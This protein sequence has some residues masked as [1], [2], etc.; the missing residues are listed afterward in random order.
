MSL[1]S[2][3]L[4]N[5]KSLPW[6]KKA[7]YQYTIIGIAFG[8]LFPLFAWFLDAYML[9]IEFF[10]LDSIVRVHSI[11]YT[12]YIIDVAPL[13]LGIMAYII[14]KKQEISVY[15]ANNELALILDS[16]QEGIYGVDLKGRATFANPASL[17]LIGY[18]LEEV[19]GK[20][21]HNLMHH[22]KADG[23]PYPK[24]ECNIYKAFSE[25]KAYNITDEVFWR[26]DGISFPVEYTSNPIYNKKGAVTGAVVVFRDITERK[27]AEDSLRNQ[28]EYL[29]IMLANIVEGII[30]INEDGVIESFNK[31]A[32]KIFEYDAKEVIG[33]NVKMLMPQPYKKNHDSYLQNYVNTGEEKI[34]GT[35]GREVTGLRKGGSEFP[36]ELGVNLVQ[37]D[38]KRHF[39]GIVRDISEKIKFEE[40]ELKRTRELEFVNFELSMAKSEADEA[41]RAKSEFLANMSH[42]IRTPMNG[43]MGMSELLLNTNLTS[44]QSSYTKTVIRSS[45]ALLELIDD[46]L[47]FSKI[48]SGRMELESVVFDLQLLMEDVVDLLSIKTREKGVELIL[49]YKAETPRYVTGDPVRVR[50]IIYNLAG[51]AIKFTAEGHVLIEVGVIAFEYDKVEI[52]IAVEDTGLG[53]PKDKQELIFEKFSQTDM[54][55]TRKYGGTG[56]GLAISKQLA[57]MMEGDINVKSEEGKGSTFEVTMRL[58]VS[59]KESDSLIMPKADIEGVKVLVVD[60]NEVARGVI[61]E[62][63]LNLGVNVESAA[64]GEDALSKLRNAHKSGQDFSI[65]TIDDIMEDIDGYDLGRA[66]KADSDIKDISLIMV[67]STPKRGDGKEA[68]KIGF[69]GYLTKPLHS[70]ELEEAISALWGAKKENVDKIFI[71]R[72]TLLESDELLNDESCKKISFK[73]V[74]ILLVDDN[75]V[76]QMVASKMLETFNCSVSIVDNGRKAVESFKA[77]KF[78]LILMDCFMPEMDGFEATKYIRNLEKEDKTPI[79][80]FTA[81]VLQGDREK[82]IVAG[83]DDYISKPIKQRD[84]ENILIKWIP[85][86][87][88][89][90]I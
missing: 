18:S 27:R 21:L 73:S 5:K 81:N 28:K 83:M 17:K 80:A 55:T 6:Y 71:T 10:S 42:E 49:R 84:I 33:N 62:K 63:L 50:Q 60:D 65:V 12:H 87:K 61:T 4:S 64:S 2:V 86:E 48:E 54:A 15:K 47:D 29:D 3:E 56:L 36:L 11:S 78:D 53:I 9:G 43:I 26:K 57:G 8:M 82:C 24:E 19:I 20:C 77:E 38:G 88:Q 40:E 46:I 44:K 45:E 89:E 39:A 51:N 72:H 1:N 70:S 85:K 41:L 13:V 31:V 22:T 69:S 74:K 76:N 75:M 67:A 7:T 79:I 23:S 52:K 34:I 58:K 59:D 14:G 25:D 68:R 66:I 37:I 32:E 16:V 35:A 30:T 90:N